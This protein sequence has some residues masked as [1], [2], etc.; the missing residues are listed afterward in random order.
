VILVNFVR[1]GLSFW[2][3]FEGTSSKVGL[4]DEVFRWGIGGYRCDFVWLAVSTVGVLIAGIYFKQRS[5]PY[6]KLQGD[7]YL[8]IA[9]LVAFLVWLVKVFAA[10]LVDFG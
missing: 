9:W 3:R 8:C 1:F 10:G 7:T 4:A 6:P 2:P 5:E